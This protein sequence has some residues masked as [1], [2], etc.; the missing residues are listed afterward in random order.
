MSE[1]INRVHRYRNWLPILIIIITRRIITVL[2]SYF[3]SVRTG[4]LTELTMNGENEKKNT[5]R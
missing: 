2:V 1:T 3:L 4:A 5:Q